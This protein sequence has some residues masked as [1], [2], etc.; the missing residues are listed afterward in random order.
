MRELEGN[1]R[2]AVELLVALTIAVVTF[3]TASGVEDGAA[4]AVWQEH[5]GLTRGSLVDRAGHPLAVTVLSNHR[6]RR[7]YP[8]SSLAPIVGF[9]D[10]ER[11][12]HGLERTYNAL[13]GA[14]QARGDWRSFF[15]HL[16]G[17]PAEG[18]RVRL[19]LDS[20]LQ[21]VADAAL[22]NV[23]GA[24][25]A[26][27]PASGAV[28]AM[29]S[30]P[31]CSP[32]RLATASGY[33]GCLHDPNRPMQNRA[34]QL[35]V[36]PGSSF[37]IVTLSAAMDTGKFQL[38]TEFR[39]AD[40]FGPSPYFDNSVY[41]SNITREDFYQR[42]WLTLVQALAFSDNFSFAHIGLTL[43][44]P[45]LL[46]YA[47][48]YLVGRQIPFDFPVA[49]SVIANGHTPP[50]TSELARSAFGAEV[51]RVTPLQMALIA[52]TVA[53]RGSMMA[54]HLVQDIRTASG[55]LVWRYHPHQLSR[56]MTP[57]G[58]AKVVE[59]MVFVVDHGSGFKAQ[60]AGMKVGGKTGTAAS[61]AST[62]HAWFIA[63]APAYHPVVAVA[64]LHEYS[65]EAFEY[66]A[67]IA[68][69]ILVAALQERGYH[70]K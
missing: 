8:L 68:R 28:L 46:S 21:R 26:L 34:L 50:S 53:N 49:P 29:L 59:G 27:D 33:A 56:V 44:A 11:H 2:W 60:I 15:L 65:G 40:A 51:D 24:V 30:K 32:S 7:V 67:P 36:P 70:V 16:A 42:G 22:G 47:H 14:T 38:S 20:R 69:K 61:G 19:T 23:R 5:Q 58:A 10:P 3:L 31:Y 39:G 1:T 18:D 13:L 43:G 63:F 4:R 64:V 12:W 17:K 45:T 37:K 48:R 6:A 55:R 35:R 25:V 54:P 41:P 66:A 57:Q 62:P 52:E 9:L